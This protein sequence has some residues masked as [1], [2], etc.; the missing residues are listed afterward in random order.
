MRG[1]Q[2]AVSELVSS[3]QPLV[4]R[5]VNNQTETLRVGY[6][7]A[8]YSDGYTPGGFAQ[9]GKWLPKMDR[10]LPEPQT[11]SVTTWVTKDHIQITP[12]EKLWPRSEIDAHL[13]SKTL[14]YAA[15]ND[16]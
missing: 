1:I 3:K 5:L 15:L 16:E 11:T 8:G 10:L 2:S 4:N 14:P 13:T 9:Q 6:T 12:P 7:S